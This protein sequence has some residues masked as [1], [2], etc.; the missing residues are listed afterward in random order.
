[1]KKPEI[2]PYVSKTVAASLGRARQGNPEKILPCCTN[3]DNLLP[4]EADDVN[5]TAMLRCRVCH[6]GHRYM[7]AE[8]G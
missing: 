1:M 4:E 5:M 7:L 3:S 6:R 2:N 8:A